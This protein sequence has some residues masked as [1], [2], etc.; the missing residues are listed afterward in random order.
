MQNHA[1][2]YKNRLGRTAKM[3]SYEIHSSIFAEEIV[4]LIFQGV[5]RETLFFHEVLGDK[6]QEGVPVPPP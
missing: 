1:V 5:S 2:T 6:G 3:K 4:Q